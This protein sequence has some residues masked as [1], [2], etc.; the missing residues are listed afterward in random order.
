MMAQVL[1]LSFPTQA[2][3]DATWTGSGSDT[4]WSTAGNWNN[5][6]PTGGGVAFFE[7][8][9]T[10]PP[11]NLD[12]SVELQSIFFGGTTGS[13]TIGSTNASTITL[14]GSDVFIQNSLAGTNQTETI[15]VPLLLN[16][17]NQQFGNWANP[18]ANDTLVLSGGLTNNN[19]NGYNTYF[20]GTGNGVIS[21]NVTTGVNQ[22]NLYF[23]SV[24]T[25]TMSGNNAYVGNTGVY[26]GTLNLDYTTNNTSKISASNN[27][28]LSSLIIGS[29]QYNDVQGD[30]GHVNFI[31]N[32]SA[33]TVQN[34]GGTGVN[35]GSGTITITP[36]GSQ[37]ATVNLGHI[38]VTWANL[39]LELPTANA[40]ATATNVNINGIVA[41]T[42]G[43]NYGEQGGRVTVNQEYWAKSAATATY[44]NWSSSTSTLA[45][46]E[47]NGTQ[48]TFTYNNTPGNLNAYQTYYVVNSTGSTFQVALA[49]GGT[50]VTLS[51][52]GS[53]A[54]V[55]TSGAITAL[56]TDDGVNFGA[57]NNITIAGTTTLSGDNAANTLRFD[58]GS[59]GLALSGHNLDVTTGGI[60]I[61]KDVTSNV[62]ISGG[63]LSSSSYYNGGYTIDQFGS[64]TLTISA[65][66]TGNNIA[67]SKN[68]TGTLILSGANTFTSLGNPKIFLNEGT[69]QLGND[70]GLGTGN[71]LQ[72]GVAGTLDLHG[73]SASFSQ[74][75]TDGGTYG[76]ANNS[77]GTALAQEGLTANIGNQAAGTLST[78]TVGTSVGTGGY[79]GD[80]FEG[81][82][83]EASGAILAFATADNTGGGTEVITLKGAHNG[84]GGPN[85]YNATVPVFVQQITGSVTVGSGSLL[86]IEQGTLLTTGALT[87][88]GILGAYFPGN[89]DVSSYAASY[90]TGTGAFADKTIFDSTLYTSDSNTFNVDVN[91]VGSV[92]DTFTGTF[93]LSVSDPTTVN[94]INAGTGTLV[95]THTIYQNGYGGPGLTNTGTAT[96]ILP[97]LVT[98][99]G[100]SGGYLNNRG[101]GTIIIDPDNSGTQGSPTEILPQG[102]E[103]FQA[104]TLKIA[105]TGTSGNTVYLLGNNYTGGNT[106]GLVTKGGTTLLLDAGGN[107]GVTLT[108]GNTSNGNA[109]IQQNGYGTL[110]IGAAQGLSSLGS[111]TGDRLNLLGTSGSLPTVTNGIVSTWIV[112]Q[113][114]NTSTADGLSQKGTFLTYT[115]S[116]TSNTDTGFAAYN[117]TSSNFTA[118]T[119][120]TTV[121][122]VNTGVSLGADTTVYSLEVDNGG[123]IALGNNKLIIGDGTRNPVG[124]ILNGGAITG[125]TLQTNING[126][127]LDV[128]TSN[129]GGTISSNITG[130][131]ALV[132]FGPGTLVLTGSNSYDVYTVINGGVVDVAGS[133]GALSS[134][135]SI[136]FGGGVLQGND[137]QNGVFT[138]PLG[139]PVNGAVVNWAPLYQNSSGGGF[140]ARGGTWTI[141]IGGVGAP[142]Q[143]VWGSQRDFL[144][145]G[146]VLMFGSTT[147]NGAVLFENP[148]D[149]GFTISSASDGQ[150][151]GMGQ[152]FRTI[153]VQAN[154]SDHGDPLDYNI[155][156]DYAEI[157]GVISANPIDGVTPAQGAFRGL[158]KTGNG[159]L[160]LAADNTYTGATAI[161]GGTL[162]IYKD[163]NL[164]TAPSSAYALNTT[165]GLSGGAITPGAVVISGGATL[166][167]G[168]DPNG[169]AVDMVL[170]SNRTILLASGTSGSVTPSNIN[171][172]QGAKATFGGMIADY[173]NEVGAL[174]KTGGGNLVLTGNNN[175]YSGGTTVSFGTLTVNNTSGSGTSSGNVAVQSGAVLRG[176]GYIAPSS[177]NSV[178]IGDGGNLHPGDLPTVSTTPNG[179]LSL[180]EATGSPQPVLT[181]NT[182]TIHSGVAQLT[183]DLGT[184]IN[185]ITQ[186]GATFSGGLIHLAGS[187]SYIN[188]TTN[189]AGEVVFNDNIVEINALTGNALAHGW[190]L[191][192]SGQANT[193]YLGLNGNADTNGTILSGLTLASDF[194][195]STTF[196]GSRLVLEDGNI[197]VDVVP[198]PGTWAMLIIGLV[199]LLVPIHRARRMSSSRI[200]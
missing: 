183:F 81:G 129:D 164:G 58:A 93:G 44:D 59:T 9:S 122:L 176:T 111:A 152:Y 132:K 40:I 67:L 147:A 94:I 89:V 24:G 62:T 101:I 142:T 3:A 106:N 198:E 185:G 115:G 194:A 20:V 55:Q 180:T 47:T 104:G 124:L 165:P 78:F 61:G 178:T 191:L 77:V 102:G 96:T 169:D 21:G 54:E 159:L 100:H 46:A 197:Y 175:S 64:G 190:Y 27:N 168:Q 186:S 167:M 26:A 110:I 5:S 163:S 127:D 50:P 114:D 29:R 14:D 120:N 155:N 71:I 149:L 200:G 22:L 173:I 141:S 18:S 83:T 113:D 45:G 33:P 1:L 25:W 11:V 95:L 179:H 137:S 125:G 49:P 109:N 2:R 105:P 126:S 56:T 86:S 151:S 156:T 74:L 28:G 69:I 192:V 131:A 65:Q 12:V 135:A 153:N 196:R 193:D 63:T 42:L 172:W 166:G 134:A 52:D 117:F 88:N 91:L 189:A 48:V 68:G 98:Q 53:G 39:D 15:S 188:L 7:N 13:V 121:E 36:G 51:N 75:Y 38:E 139:D 17:P 148:I 6:Y 70:L 108:L 157:D 199:L 140:A 76:L 60:L 154:S 133:A 146:G 119:N 87:L 19:G 182:P 57:N 97:G 35:T 123:S 30:S 34:V 84:N 90:L 73:Y 158:A 136:V 195:N 144:Q 103:V 8:S 150:F 10:Q 112:G 181:V 43:N 128:Y 161:S 66:L 79:I 72:M 187:S 85:V 143:L 177:G 174:N 37:T 31:G 99:A 32:A 160:A 118:A 171:V 41:T 4:N 116:G 82:L 162:L 107:A 92:S 130:N 170:S 138:R 23:D 145:D 80:V 16:N 184:G